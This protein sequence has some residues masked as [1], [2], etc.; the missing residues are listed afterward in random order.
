MAA[1]VLA[2]AAGVE[3]RLGRRAGVLAGLERGELARRAAGIVAAG[4]AGGGG[5]ARLARLAGLAWRRQAL[6]SR[7]AMPFPHPFEWAG[8]PQGE[9]EMHRALVKFIL[10]RR[11]PGSAPRPPAPQ[12]GGEGPPPAGPAPPP[13]PP[14]RRERAAPPASAAAVGGRKRRAP[15]GDVLEGQVAL[16]RRRCREGPCA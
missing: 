7:S 15:A 10:R 5:R 2:A 4:G 6:R 14:A 1:A 3:A 12:P 8:H 9:A 16:L 13:P 11:S